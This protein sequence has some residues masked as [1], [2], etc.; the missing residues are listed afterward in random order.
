MSTLL[1]TYPRACA[2]V[3]EHGHLPGAQPCRVIQD[4]SL[5]VEIAQTMESSLEVRDIVRPTLVKLASSM[6]MTRGA[7]T[8]RHDDHSPD[9]VEVV[10]LDRHES[11]QDY[12][13]QARP[14]FD[15][16]IARG[17]ALV[18][19]D[20]AKDEHFRHRQLPVDRLMA[21][22]CVPVK[23]GDETLGTLSIERCTDPRSSLSGDVNLLRLIARMMAQAVHWRLTAEHRLKALREE[24][25][26]L[27]E[28]IQRAFKPDNMVGS[29]TAMQL[30]YRHIEQVAGSEATVL[31]RGESGVGKE[32]VA[33]AVHG[34]SR[35]EG[36]AFVKFSCAALPESIIESELFGHEKG[37]F[38][39]AITM[40]RGRF[41]LADGGTIFLDEIGDLAPSTQVKLLRVLQEREFER[42]GS[43]RALRC[44]V[45]V[46]AATSRD[47]E[48]MMES[49][50]FRADLYYR[51]NVF[52][53][54]VP[55][56]RERKSDLLPLA[57]HFVEKCARRAGRSIRRIS[58]AAIDLIMAYHWPGNVR[59]LENCIERAVLLCEGD[60]VEAQHLPPTLQMP[61]PGAGTK[62][63][64][65]LKAAL[66]GL[67]HELICAELKATGGNMAQ[68]A[69]N[70]EITERIMALRVKEYQIDLKRFRRSAD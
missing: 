38:T 51:L 30:V 54:Y 10:G 42:V 64:G 49:G 46:I 23:H 40:R 39:G 15:Q 1:T 41:E 55:A 53:I 66:R 17:R 28:Q 50:R 19:T 31:I 7:I 68:A 35:R 57:D 63:V 34:Q 11:P 36:R 33:H 47:L 52:P 24:N 60:S 16:V 70:L 43:S 5:L 62:P 25:A 13:G 14:L 2:R 8:L 59:E 20:L 44:D 21:F 65:P 69:R 67:E 37:A 48:A 32:L 12:W 29:S 18:V 22:L 3:T 6:G 4:L 27:Q 45:R 58:T 56:L 26:R 61:H 9:V